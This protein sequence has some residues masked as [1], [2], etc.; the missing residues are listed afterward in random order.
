MLSDLENFVIPKNF[1]AIEIVKPEVFS[2]EN[3]PQS[4]ALSPQE[5]KG[6]NLE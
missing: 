2:I 4:P 6:V 1:M 3:T 5:R